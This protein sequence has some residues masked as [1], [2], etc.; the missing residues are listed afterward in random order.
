MARTTS[1]EAY[2]MYLAMKLHFTTEGYDFFKYRGKTKAK[3]DISNRRD[4]W[5]FIN[6]VN[7]YPKHEELK[8]HFVANFAYGKL[9]WPGELITPDAIQ[10]YQYWRKYIDSL[11]Y[12]FKADLAKIEDLMEEHNLEFDD[13]LLV[14]EHQKP[15]LLQFYDWRVITAETVITMNEVLHFFPHWMKRIEDDII[16]PDTAMR[17]R[18]YRP[19][20]KIDVNK[21]RQLMK[22][23]FVD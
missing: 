10:T 12:N 13:L 15:W 8:E 7:K 1:I 16:W 14:K 6:L 5:A 2:Q 22:D 18:K 11:S 3:N 19:F 21:S 23:R 20:L 17:L 4:K 9:T